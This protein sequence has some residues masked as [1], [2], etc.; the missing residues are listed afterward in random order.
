MS[1]LI[2]MSGPACV[3]KGPVYKAM[4]FY[5]PDIQVGSIPVKKSIECRLKPGMS[6]PFSFREHSELTK[7]QIDQLR[8][9]IRPDD[10]YQDFYPMATILGWNSQPDEY[11]VGDCRGFPQG[12]RRVDVLDAFK[13]SDNVY[14]EVYYTLGAA[15]A[16][17]RMVTNL[18]GTNISTV[19]ISPLSTQEMEDI[20]ASGRDLDEYIVTLMMHKQLVRARSYGIGPNYKDF[21]K[22]ANDAIAEIGRMRDFNTVIVNHDGEGNPNWNQRLITSSEG[23]KVEFDPAG[24]LSG[25]AARTLGSFV[26]LF[27]NRLR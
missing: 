5:R 27:A 21:L 4:R 16:A 2:L 8:G 18:T 24:S 6:S 7:P 17:S 13:Q 26:G 25:D 10:D 22:R 3:G 20:K 19:F 11:V 14:S 15:F 1:N 12:I 9:M 23:N